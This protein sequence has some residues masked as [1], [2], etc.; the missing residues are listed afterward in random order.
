MAQAAQRISSPAQQ[1]SRQVER[2]TTPPSRAGGA[3]LATAKVH[4]IVGA[5]VTGRIVWNG[6]RLANVDTVHG[7]A[8]VN[9]RLMSIPWHAGFSTLALHRIPVLRD[10]VASRMVSCVCLAL[11]LGLPRNVGRGASL[12][13]RPPRRRFPSCR[14][15]GHRACSP[16]NWVQRTL[17]VGKLR[18]GRK[19]GRGLRLGA[20]QG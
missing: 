9:K 1:I 5:Q 18:L 17:G 11:S 14:R 12:S 8:A 13:S 20:S 10:I 2:S 3:V 4:D 16:S 7:A 15:G 19:Q 6:R